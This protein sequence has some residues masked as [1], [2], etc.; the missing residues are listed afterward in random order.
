MNFS[1]YYRTCIKKSVDEDRAQIVA[2]FRDIIKRGARTGCR[3]VNYYKGLPLSYPA[4][5]VEID[6]GTLELDVHKQQAVALEE[7]RYSFIKCDHFDSAILAGVRDVN[8]RSMTAS[9]NNFTFVEI[10]AERRSA[11]RLDLEPPTN[12]EIKG[13]GLTMVGKVIDLSLGGFSIRL[14]HRCEIPKGTLVALKVDVPNLLQGSLACLKTRAKLVALVE[15][16]GFDTCRFAYDAD[17]ESEAMITRYI[18]QRQVE[19]I[20]ELKERS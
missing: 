8:V 13:D 20:R 19:I 11:L 12:A 14:D 2:A 17:A 15:G 18:F 5:L 10:M 6:H 16:D 9:L 3:L 4:T 1:P 7:N